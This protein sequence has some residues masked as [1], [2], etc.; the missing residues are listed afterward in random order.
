MFT[1]ADLPEELSDLRSSIAP[2]TLVVTCRREF[3]SL[4]EDG[5]YELAMITDRIE[6]HD[7]DPAWVPDSAPD[8]VQRVL[9]GDPTIGLPGDGGLT[10]TKQTDP[11]IVLLKPRLDGIPTDFHTYLIAEALLDIALDHPEHPLG[12]FRDQYSALQAATDDDSGLTYRLAGALCEAWCGLGRRERI[13]EWEDTWP[14]IYAAWVDAGEQLTE[15]VNELPDL[16]RNGSMGFAGATELACS[17]I[18]H[19]LAL[20]K[21]FD[22]LDVAA[23]RE[24]GP[25]FAVRW[26]ERT[27][28]QIQDA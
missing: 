3:E 26:T 22:A 11:P 21:P 12:F 14:T 20:P 23:Y 10:W 27:V 15:R 19:D 2:D 18:K 7:Y 9:D 1:E 24:H 16:L 8:V 17:G 13:A 4:P 25:A 5:L 28:S 6:S